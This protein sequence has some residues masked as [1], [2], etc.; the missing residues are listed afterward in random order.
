MRR[1]LVR[2]GE[3]AALNGVRND[4]RGAQ[5]DHKSDAQDEKSDRTCAPAPSRQQQRNDGVTMS[6]A[7]CGSAEDWRFL[8]EPAF[9]APLFKAT[10]HTKFVCTSINIRMQI[11]L[12]WRDGHALAL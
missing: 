1:S 2:S 4:A 6:V 10:V 11:S 3:P 5:S 8:D 9:A 7:E 12:V